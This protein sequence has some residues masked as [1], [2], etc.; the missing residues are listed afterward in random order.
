MKIFSKNPLFFA[1]LFP[2]FSDMSLTLFGQN[3]SQSKTLNEASP[4]YY[5]LLVSPW[6]FLLGSILWFV[7]W[8][9]IFLKINNSLKLFLSILFISAHSWGSAS[10][11][12]KLARYN[13]IFDSQNQASVML[14]WSLVI[15]YFTFIA[16]LAEICF[17]KYF[18][19]KK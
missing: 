19:N 9:Y 10:W 6:V 13:N 14:I 2:A 18:Q 7:I 4:A 16:Y 8:Y 12:W 17:T 5:F 1:F 11:L 3:F 15:L